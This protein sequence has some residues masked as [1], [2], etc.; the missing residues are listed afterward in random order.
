VSSQLQANVRTRSETRASRHSSRTSAGVAHRPTLLFFYSPTCGESRRTEGFLAQVLQR[1][2]NH[3]TFSLI[4]IDYNS[5]P[6]LAARCR[7]ER[8]PAIVVIE[9]KRVRARLEQ[10]RGGA[11]I[12]AILAPWLK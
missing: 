7:I 10:P 8:P 5:H 6:D 1:R 11:Q 9:E 3:D 4:R 2:R 12:Q